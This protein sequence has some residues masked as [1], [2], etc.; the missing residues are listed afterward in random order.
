MARFFF[1]L[2][3]FTAL[4][5]CADVCRAPALAPGLTVFPHPDFLTA[6]ESGTGLRGRIP[7][8][9]R[10]AAI[11]ESAFERV[12]GFSTTGPLFVNRSFAA[13]WFGTVGPLRF[14]LYD[15][16]SGTPVAAESF[17][18]DARDIAGILPVHPLKA[19]HDYWFEISVSGK[20]PCD[21]EGPHVV[22]GE[23]PGSRRLPTRIR[24]R[25]DSNRRTVLVPFRTQQSRNLLA[26]AASLLDRS[27]TPRVLN[28]RPYAALTTAGE[29]NPDLFGDAPP[30]IDG[31]RYGSR[32]WAPLER[33]G[34]VVI[35]EIETAELRHD[36]ALRDDTLRE[37]ERRRLGYI[38]TLPHMSA[39]VTGP[40]NL[41]G[42]VPL[43]LFSH[44]LRACKETIFSIADTLS[45]YGFAVAAI[46]HVEHGSRR[47]VQVSE[48][49]CGESTPWGFFAGDPETLRDNLRASALDL[50]QLK[51]ALQR[52]HA[53]LFDFNADGA[54]DF[55]AEHPAVVAI[56]LGSI[57]AALLVSV[58]PDVEVAVFNTLLGSSV[59]M[60]ETVDDGAGDY[61]LPLPG[62]IATLNVALVQTVAEAADPLAYTDALRGR[63]LDLLLQEA[64]D[65][66]VVPNEST[67]RFA[68]ALGA[69]QIEPVY[70]PVAG[71]T[72]ATAPHRP[73]G[74]H[75]ST[76]ALVQVEPANHSFL[77]LPKDPAILEPAR[78]QVGYF[79]WSHYALGRGVVQPF[80]WPI[81]DG[82]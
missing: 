29:P 63:R 78:M 80:P 6:D 52:A 45:G 9:Y 5:A 33:I 28:A 21:T 3:L 75:Q 14:N 23:W 7:A 81:D 57:V 73:E 18:N 20:A 74:R 68:R 44:P 27:A 46:D 59:G 72:R 41:G 34:R 16:V 79:L 54:V 60:L 37:H 30:L 69:V 53:P 82:P 39:R 56:S 47:S 24:A 15:G 13:A 67:E 17:R 32:P 42:R 76:R 10:P 4:T 22:T 71:L 36:G 66:A 11:F 48:Y 26:D 43:V 51:L 31:L 35:G 77:L 65:D 8:P 40:V 49:V 61:A 1:L 58:S 55:D 50:Y 2:A 38:L 19:G 64:V 12:D 70:R 62:D 25:L